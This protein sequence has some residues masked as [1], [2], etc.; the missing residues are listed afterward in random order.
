MCLWERTDIGTERVNTLLFS[1]V[2]VIKFVFISRPEGKAV[3]IWKNSGQF[4]PASNHF[5]IKHDLHNFSHSSTLVS[6]TP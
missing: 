5:Q 3:S 6:Y 1:T 4:L 2:G